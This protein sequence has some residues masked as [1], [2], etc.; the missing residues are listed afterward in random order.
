MHEVSIETLGLGG[1]TIEI[2]YLP[3]AG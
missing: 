2:T 1:G 3:L